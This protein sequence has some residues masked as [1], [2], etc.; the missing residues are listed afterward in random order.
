MLPAEPG[1]LMMFDLYA[2]DSEDPENAIL[3]EGTYPVDDSQSAGTASES[4]TFARILDESGE[5]I[6]KILDGGTVTVKHNEDAT[7]AIAG[8]FITTEGE[9]F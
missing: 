3:P 7:Y 6:Y 1:M 9:K 2:V 8:E 5:V 4:Y